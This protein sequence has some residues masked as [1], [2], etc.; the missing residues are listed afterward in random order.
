MA[1]EW[2]AAW[3]GVTVGLPRLFRPPARREAPRQL[4]IQGLQFSEAGVVVDP[5]KAPQPHIPATPGRMFLLAG[6]ARWLAHRQQYATSQQQQ[7]RKERPKGQV[8]IMVD[9]DRWALEYQALEFAIKRACFAVG[10]FGLLG[11][12]TYDAGGFRRMSTEDVVEENRKPLRNLR[13][14]AGMYRRW[15]AEHRDEI[16]ADIAREHE[17][18]QW[19]D[20]YNSVGW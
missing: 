18:A 6:W 10:A 4:P 16:E 9:D 13:A 14:R 8:G 1:G 12:A 20:Y 5:F 7:L 3:M 19:D 11:G 2:L 15:L 17:A